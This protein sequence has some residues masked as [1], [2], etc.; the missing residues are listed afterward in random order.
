MR[1]I[2]PQTHAHAQRLA[3]AKALAT[4][5]QRRDYIAKVGESEGRFYAKWLRDDLA[6]WHRAKKAGRA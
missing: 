2:G 4:D 1:T 5:D 6:A 3:H